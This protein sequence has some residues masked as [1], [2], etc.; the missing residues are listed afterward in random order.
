VNGSRRR[1]LGAAAGG[2]ALALAG[3][4]GSPTVAPV[5]GATRTWRMGFSANPPRPSVDVALQGIGVWS[6]R[7]D[8]AIVHEDVPWAA[9]LA[10]STPDAIIDRDQGPLVGFYRSKGLRIVYLGD[11]TNG[12]ARE[13]EAAALVAAG[14]SLAEPDIQV[15]HRSWMLAVARRL[16]PDVIGLAAE[17]N[18]VRAVAPAATYNAVMQ[19]ANGAAT[20]L[21]AAGV[22]TELMTS[23]QV[24]TAWGRLVGNGVYAGIAADARDFAFT[25]VLGLSSYPYFGY[26]DPDDL[27]AD[28]FSRPVAGRGLPAMVLEGGWTSADVTGVSSSPARQARYIR[29]Q[30]ALLDGIQARAWCHLLFADIDFASLPPPVPANLAL[31]TNIGLADSNFNPKPALAEWDALFA[32]RLLG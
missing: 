14:R 27:P 20:A 25:Q 28:Y 21:R 8:L 6:Q 15:L 3:C 5:A 31:F 4:G 11:I 12:L 23:V 29:R 18:L 9:L 24:E 19:A 22:T 16:Q 13:S 1:L 7:A 10:G 17:T 2:A 26:A 32:R 30:A